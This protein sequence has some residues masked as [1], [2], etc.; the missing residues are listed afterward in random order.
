MLGLVVVPKLNLALQRCKLGGLLFGGR[1]CSIKD[2]IPRLHI[3]QVE[4]NRVVAINILV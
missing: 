4:L 2:G 1:V 3:E